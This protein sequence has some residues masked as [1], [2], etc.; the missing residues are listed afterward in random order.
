MKKLTITLL[1]DND[2]DA[3]KAVTRLNFILPVLE[4]EY[5]NKKY[6]FSKE[7]KSREPRKFLRANFGKK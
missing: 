5:D 3:Y 7:D 4:A 1:V 6:K 2:I